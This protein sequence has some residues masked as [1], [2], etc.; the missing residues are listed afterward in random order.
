MAQNPRISRFSASEGPVSQNVNCKKVANNHSRQRGNFFSSVLGPLVPGN[1][2]FLFL[3]RARNFSKCPRPKMGQKPT[4][5]PFPTGG[6][7]TKKTLFPRKLRKTI[8]DSVVTFFSISGPP[9]CSAD[10]K[11]PCGACCLL[12]A[13]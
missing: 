10:Q 2:V 7:P 5:S 8:L 11:G 4:K 3:A 9:F 1:C 6:G 12:L 13:C